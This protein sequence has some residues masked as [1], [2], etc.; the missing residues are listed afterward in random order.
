MG[1]ND[2]QGRDT[3]NVR[4]CS[5]RQYSP[6]FKVDLSS[7]SSL[8]KLLL[9][10]RLLTHPSKYISSKYVAMP[11]AMAEA[12][13]AKGYNVVSGG[14]DNHCMLIDLRTKISRIDR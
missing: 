12:F 10:A 3:Q 9:L 14:T 4:H 8:P 6:V 5:T 13:V 1:Q 11:R 2:T 7:M